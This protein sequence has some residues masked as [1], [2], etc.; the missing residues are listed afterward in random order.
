MSATEHPLHLDGQ[1]LQSPLISKKPAEHEHK[2]VEVLRVAP[3]IQVLQVKT[4]ITVGAAQMAQRLAR[5]GKQTN[6]PPAPE[7]PSRML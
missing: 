1:A 5:H 6:P 2:L 4:L 3:T 7:T